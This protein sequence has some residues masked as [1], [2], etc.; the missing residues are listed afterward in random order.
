MA[1]A[2]DP[3]ADPTALVG[4]RIRR[5]T[6]TTSRYTPWADIVMTVP[7]RDGVCWLIA[8]ID[9]DVDVWRVDD[10]HAHYQFE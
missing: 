7:S 10:P 4:R 3:T 2:P 5:S 8:Y 9:G 6:R 1:I